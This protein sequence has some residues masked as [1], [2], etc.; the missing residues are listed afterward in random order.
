MSIRCASCFF[1]FLIVE[2]A[3]LFLNRGWKLIILAFYSAQCGFLYEYD[4]GYDRVNTKNEKPLQHMER[5]H[6]NPSASEDPVLQDLAANNSARVFTTDTVLSMIMCAPRSVYPWDIQLVKEGDKLFMDKREGG[7]LDYLTVNENAADPPL[8]VN[9]LDP[10]HQSQAALLNTPSALSQ[11]ATFVNENFAWQVVKEAK[12]NRVDFE[13][14]NPFYDPEEPAALASCG[15][16]YRRFDLSTN[17]GEEVDLVVRTEVDALLRGSLSS[18]SA[19]AAPSLNSEEETYILLKS[20]FEFDSRA[21]GSGGAPD[22]RTKLDS[23]R[24]AVVAT[25]MKNNSLKLARWATMGVLAGAGGMK[26]G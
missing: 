11:Q 10:A 20:L 22:W 3:Y 8:E 6:Y 12:E 2:Q 23:Q 14:P 19:T 9:Q 7:P 17:D 21:Q 15:Y 4:R 25:E 18:S 1:F 24:G 13:K 26:V 5:L 16:R